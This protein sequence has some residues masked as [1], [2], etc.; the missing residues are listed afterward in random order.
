MSIKHGSKGWLD[1]ADET[2]SLELD[3]SNVS[4]GTNRVLTMP[5]GDLDLS[6][7]TSGQVL[8]SNGAGSAPSMQDAGGAGIG[9]DQTWQ[10]MTG[11]RSKNT[12]YTNTTGVPIQLGI[13]CESDEGADYFTLTISGVGVQSWTM[14]SYEYGQAHNFYPIIPNNATYRLA[15]SGTTID[16][17][18][19]L[20]LR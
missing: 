16:S 4:T 17:Y 9:V 6:A 7:G 1:G 3:V 5:D 12:T 19:W 18:T 15:F 20:E 11:S 13:A 2:K 10:N 8:T 14:S